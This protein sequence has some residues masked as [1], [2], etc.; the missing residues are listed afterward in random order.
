MVFCIS[1]GSGVISPFFVSDFIDLSPVFFLM[2]LAKVLS[3]LLIFSK[4]QLL[5]SLIFSIVSFVSVHFCSDFY[6]LFSS[7]NFGL[8]SSFS[9]W[10]RCKVLLLS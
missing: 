4:N 3:I 6:D 10:F 9:S 5:S 7:S 8:C 2:S 1:L